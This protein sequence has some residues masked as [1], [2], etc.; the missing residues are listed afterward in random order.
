M[1]APASYYLHRG[2]RM[3]VTEGVTG[4]VAARPTQGAEWEICRMYVHPDLH[5]TGLAHTLLDHA[6]AH[7][8]KQGATRLVL[9]T[10]TRFARAH[11]FYERRGYARFGQARA[12]HD[13]SNTHEFA[14]ASPSPS[15]SGSG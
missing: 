2:G 15:G 9:W 5:G 7:V 14:Y 4:T 12:L 3:W 8:A 11:R 6:E 1:R 13:R 10:D